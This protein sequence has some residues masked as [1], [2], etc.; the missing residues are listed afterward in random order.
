M[1]GLICAKLK[2]PCAVL[3]VA[4]FQADT[5][6]Q[7][8]RAHALIGDWDG[9]FAALEQLGGWVGGWMGGWADSFSFLLI[10]RKIVNQKFVYWYNGSV[11][12]GFDYSSPTTSVYGTPA[13]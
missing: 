8:G 1:I 6:L 7:A 9:A 5:V 2:P 10:P 3:C 13:P 4:R 11:V 12:F